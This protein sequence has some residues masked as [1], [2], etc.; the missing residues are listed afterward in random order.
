MV[1]TLPDWFVGQRIAISSISPLQ[2]DYWVSGYGDIPAESTLEIVVGKGFT[3]EL[4]WIPE[5]YRFTITGLRFSVSA[6]VLIELIVL[7]ERKDEPGKY[8]ARGMEYGYQ[9]VVIN[10]GNLGIFT[11]NTRP[12][13]RIHNYYTKDVYYD[14]NV[15]GVLEKIKD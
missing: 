4:E 15:Y 11:E 14:F 2:I 7:E 8:Y 13:Y 12:V 9:K 6:D 3:H 1:R 5:G 10:T